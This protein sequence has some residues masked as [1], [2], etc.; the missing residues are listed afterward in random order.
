LC[1]YT[2]RYDP[3]YTFTNAVGLTM[4][5]CLTSMIAYLGTGISHVFLKMRCN[6]LPFVT[7]LRL[8]LR[9]RLSPSSRRQRMRGA[10]CPAAWHTRVAFSPSCTVMSELV[11]SSVISG[12]TEIRAHFVN[13]KVEGIT[14]LVVGDIVHLLP[15]C[16]LRNSVLPGAWIPR[17]LARF[18]TAKAT[19]NFVISIVKPT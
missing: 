2:L 10:G 18:K 17:L 6:L 15:S 1:K 7:S 3:M 8:F 9:I 13:I 12:G 5:V 19:T 4:Y 14:M 11:S 16:A